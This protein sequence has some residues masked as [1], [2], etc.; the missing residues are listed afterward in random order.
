MN[1]C[2]QRYKLHTVKR[3]KRQ[4][5]IWKMLLTLIVCVFV[6]GLSFFLTDNPVDAH[7]EDISSRSKY[8]TSIEVAPGDSLWN[9]AEEYMD[10]SYETIYDY[11]DELKG[12]NGLK[13]SKIQ[14]GQYLTV[15]YYNIDDITIEE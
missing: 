1:T 2:K 12:I 3:R 11:I 9:I 6:L 10:D 13:S 7:N 8:Y 4:L 14:A 15:S 5:L